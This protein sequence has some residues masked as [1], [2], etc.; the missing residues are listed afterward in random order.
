MDREDFAKDLRERSWHTI[1]HCLLAILFDSSYH[2]YIYIYIYN[3]YIYIL[4]YI[5]IHSEVYK[6]PLNLSKSQTTP[7]LPWSRS[8]PQRSCPWRAQSRS[9]LDHDS[10]AAR[11]ML[12]HWVPDRCFEWERLDLPALCHYNSVQH[13]DCPNRRGIPHISPCNLHLAMLP[14]SQ[15]DATLS[16][17]IW[18]GISQHVS[19]TAVLREVL[20]FVANFADAT[21]KIVKVGR[22][23]KAS[24]LSQTRPWTP[25]DLDA[26]WVNDNQ[27]A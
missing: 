18:N 23:G 21:S 5:I 13:R 7:S 22:W 3:I 1:V 4:L 16:L 12:S 17:T 20:Q 24:P 15:M 2:W 9:A 11:G 19:A 14:R 27:T 6:N 26:Q 10:L 25:L 8:Q